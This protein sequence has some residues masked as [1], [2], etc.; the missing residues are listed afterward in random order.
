MST[1]T[2]E[3]GTIKVVWIED[4]IYEIHSQMFD[5]EK[6]AA[7]F[8]QK[9]KEYII[10]SLIKQKNMEEFSWKILP[11]GNHKIYL[12][13]LRNYHRYKGSFYKVVKKIFGI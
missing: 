9:K 3:K 11:Y 8:A 13:L 4:N 1:P 10:F 12:M 5:D 2:Y 7:E 6:K